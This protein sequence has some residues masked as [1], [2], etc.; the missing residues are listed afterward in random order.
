MQEGRLVV[1]EEEEKENRE[2]SRARKSMIEESVL[3]IQTHFVGNWSV[4]PQRREER[5]GKEDTMLSV[6]LKIG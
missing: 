2:R 1:C 6:G 3:S 4:I 5:I